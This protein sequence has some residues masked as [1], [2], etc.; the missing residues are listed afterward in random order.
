MAAKKKAK[1]EREKK[2]IA[3]LMKSDDNVVKEGGLRCVLF[4]KSARKG[5][6]KYSGEDKKKHAACFPANFKPKPKTKHPG[7]KQG[8]FKAC[9][10]LRNL[11]GSGAA[12]KR[13]MLAPA[14]AAI[15]KP[16]KD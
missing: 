12:K 8:L 1:S 11:E 14:C 3:K 10:T 6:E 4:K 2:A 9:F 15:G 5:G 16:L 7:N 13:K